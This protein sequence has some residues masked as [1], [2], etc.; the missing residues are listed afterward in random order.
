MV[1]SVNEMSKVIARIWL[2]D[3]VPMSKQ[4]S[5]RISHGRGKHM[6]F[7]NPEYTAARNALTWNVKLELAK[8]G[9]I[10][11]VKCKCAIRIS[12]RG[13]FDVDNAGGFVQDALQGAAYVRDSQVI[14]A[15]YRKRLK[16]PKGLNIIIHTLE[17]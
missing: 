4:H 14:L 15:T 2:P 5:A 3:V 11:P 17:V 6:M 9:W 1:G 7:R 16:G 8:K 10:Q 13:R 12:Y